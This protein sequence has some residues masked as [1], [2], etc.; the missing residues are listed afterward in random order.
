MANVLL[1]KTSGPNLA[2]DDAPLAR[3]AAP[4]LTRLVV[5]KLP[6]HQ[7][8]QTHPTR[9]W[10]I[11]SAGVCV[12]VVALKYMQNNIC[13][14]L[15]EKNLPTESLSEGRYQARYFNPLPER[16]IKQIV[17]VS[18]KEGCPLPLEQLAY[19]ELTHY[20]M[21]GKIR[22][23]VMVFN[24]MGAKK[25]MKAFREFFRMHFPIHS[26]RLADDFAANDDLIMQH[27]VTSGFNDRE[28]ADG[29]KRR[30]M[31]A[32]GAFDVNPEQNPEV[33]G[34]QVKPESGRAYLDRENVRPGM[35]TPAI[36]ARIKKYIP[37]WGGDW[38][39]LKDYQHFQF[40]RDQF[41]APQ[42]P[43]SFPQPIYKCTGLIKMP[44]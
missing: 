3:P 19:I 22:N 13:R 2:W 34:E 36:A 39:S 25:V 38:Q 24:I 30:S 12:G 29:S 9:T 23:G 27:N 17:G 11:F 6:S 8:Q 40:R 28:I 7:E 20:D 43:N 26:I 5:Q 37:E 21:E 14:H 42:L 15:S 10:V 33:R 4:L 41:P 35:V 44:F 18:Y 1:V 32:W 16:I 31:H